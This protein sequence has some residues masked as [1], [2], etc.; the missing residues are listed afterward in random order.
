MLKLSGRLI[1]SWCIQYPCWLAQSLT[2]NGIVEHWGKPKGRLR[3]FC[4]LHGALSFN[5][6]M[7]D[8][9][10]IRKQLQGFGAL[11]LLSWITQHI[12]SIWY[13]Q[14]FVSFANRRTVLED[15]TRLR[16]M[17]L[18]H[19]LSCG[20]VIQMDSAMVTDLWNNLEFGEIV[21]AS[22]WLCG[23]KKYIKAI[24]KFRE[25]YLFWFY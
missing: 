25:S 8:P 5:R 6:T 13:R 23:G 21:W 16:T 9:T 3:G 22:K 19:Q 1:Q 2:V 18:E 4:P 15:V 11:V 12:A 10:Q 7:L 14:V 17:K 20:S 24:N